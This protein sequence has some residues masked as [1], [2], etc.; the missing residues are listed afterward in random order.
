MCIPSKSIFTLFTI[1]LFVLIE[2]AAVPAPL[3]AESA[4]QNYYRAARKA[5]Q[6]G[7][8]E[9]ALS[10]Y[11]LARRVGR[12]DYWLWYGIAQC[13]FAAGRI[14]PALS[15]LGAALARDARQS[16]AYVLRGRI[17]QRQM[18]Y[19]DAEQDYAYALRLNPNDSFACSQYAYLLEQRACR[20]QAYP[21]RVRAARLSP[22]D[23][24][25]L[26][27]AAKAAA[28]LDK[29]E[30]ALVWCAH[31]ARHAPDTPELISVQA[32]IYLIWSDSARRIG[33]IARA[34]ELLNTLLSRWPEGEHV[35]KAE[36]R[37]AALRN[38]R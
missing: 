3:Q 14:D 5:Y 11:L 37:Q 33:D 35:E 20:A 23:A 29:C 34:R 22:N 9:E 28:A 16:G 4:G 38:L 36:A 2:I 12:D 6:A 10:I 19:P 17:R 7:R 21:Y 31:A 13:H 18:R 8:S 24:R 27:A 26:L 25:V 30:E 15:A 1:I 32:D